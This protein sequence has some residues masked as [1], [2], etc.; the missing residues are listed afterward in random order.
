VD[1]LQ[2]RPEGV[3][4]EISVRPRAGRCRVGRLT[5]GRLRVEVTAA[6]EG[7]EATAQA[8]ATL[9]SAAGLRAADATLLKGV[10]DRH[11]TVLLQG[12]SLA[13]CRHA[14]GL[15]DIAGR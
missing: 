1:C 2:Q 6:P 10:R 13:A 7:G 9:A 4:V 8:L 3:V 12:A 14:L 5:G 15:D 11:K